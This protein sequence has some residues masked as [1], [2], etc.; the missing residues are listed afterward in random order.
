[1]SRTDYC[2]AEEYDLQG[3]PR[4]AG[5]VYVDSKFT[6]L[7][8]PADACGTSPAM[9]PGVITV[10]ASNKDDARW[11]YSNYGTCVDLYAPG[12]KILSA[13]YTSPSATL[14][15]SGTSMACPV[16]SGVAALYLQN[17]P[18]AGPPEVREIIPSHVT[19]TGSSYKPCLHEKQ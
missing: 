16:V 18:R 19:S 6:A 2:Q 7:F 8:C 12:A 15:A 10:A 5:R 11:A 17:S 3:G 13:T 4:S 1:M 14:V 9:L